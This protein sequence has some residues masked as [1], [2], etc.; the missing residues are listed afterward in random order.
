MQSG[1]VVRLDG[2]VREELLNDTLFLSLDQARET[3]A[4]WI[5]DYNTE[6]P[7]SSLAYPNLNRNK[8]KEQNPRNPT[9]NSPPDPHKRTATVR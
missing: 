6:R 4:A 2:K 5:G 9:N 3:V 1:Y 7:L 8:R